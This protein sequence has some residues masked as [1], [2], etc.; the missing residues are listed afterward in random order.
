[1][2]NQSDFPAG[3]SARASG[4]FAEPEV[5]VLRSNPSK[6]RSSNDVTS[7]EAKTKNW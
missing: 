1:M 2:A 6:K 7:T 4:G 5:A 3:H